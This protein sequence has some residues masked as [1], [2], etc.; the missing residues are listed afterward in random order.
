MKPTPESWEQYGHALRAYVP[1]PLPV[2][3]LVFSAQFNGRPWHQIS[4]DFKLFEIAG[5]HYDLVT[6]R[7]G[8]FAAHLREQLKGIVGRPRPQLS[9][10]HFQ[11]L[12]YE[13]YTN[14]RDLKSK[15]RVSTEDGTI[16]GN[17]S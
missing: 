14:I 11:T 15:V 12:I 8:V 10:N 9:A 3:I 4:P 7:S 13:L 16:S 6:A 1:M 5:G 2:S 17:G